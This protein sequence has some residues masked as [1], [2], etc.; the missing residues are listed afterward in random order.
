MWW[1]LRRDVAC[2]VCCLGSSQRV[3]IQRFQNLLQ[4][5]KIWKITT[6]KYLFLCFYKLLLLVFVFRKFSP[7]VSKDQP[8]F[9]NISTPTMP[10]FTGV[11]L[12]ACLI[13]CFR[14]YNLKRS[15]DLRW[16]FD[17]RCY[18]HL[19]WSFSSGFTNLYFW[20]SFLGTVHCL[21]RVST[22]Q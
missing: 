5:K 12:R 17:H 20:C 18:I 1:I 9:Y 3:R 10:V 22:I 15:V 4:K 7:L 14:S 19:R 11:L 13:Y 8:I 6:K 2:Q 16:L 21:F